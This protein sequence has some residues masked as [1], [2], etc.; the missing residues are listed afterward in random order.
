ME[1]IKDLFGLLILAFLVGLVAEWIGR[2]LH[3]RFFV[4]FLTAAYL[5]FLVWKEIDTLGTHI[6]D[7]LQLNWK[8]GV[9]LC[10][11]IV[12]LIFVII[13]YLRLL[14]ICV[15]VPRSIRNFDHVKD[16]IKTIWMSYFIASVLIIEC[17]IA[18]PSTYLASVSYAAGAS[19]EEIVTTFS[20]ILTVSSLWIG[21]AIA[22]LV[23]ATIFYKDDSE[24]RIVKY[25]HSNLQDKSTLT[26][27]EL[28]NCINQISTIFKADRENSEKLVRDY[29]SFVNIR[30]LE[31]AYT[32]AHREN[33]E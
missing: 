27:S 22:F 11:P 6:I 4:G 19:Q 1:V 28:E 24:I 25:I 18:I 16:E 33:Q 14:V 23:L 31:P 17:A 10:I 15:S 9:F 13:S 2:L 26:I 3:M 7:V 5:L 20:A 29:A 8:T 12:S 21:T 30:I 32:Q